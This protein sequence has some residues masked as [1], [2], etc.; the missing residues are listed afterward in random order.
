[1]GLYFSALTTKGRRGGATGDPVLS[2]VS[3]S[4]TAGSLPRSAS[5]AA[6]RKQRQRLDKAI[7][8]APGSFDMYVRR[9][10]PWFRPEDHAHMVDG[11]RKAGWR[12]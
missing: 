8:I 5:S 3:A 11:L 6:V 12:E 1:M 7:E 9:R 2:G 10:A 4:P